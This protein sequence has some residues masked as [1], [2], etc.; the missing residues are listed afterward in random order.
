M[1]YGSYEFEDG[2]GM[3][4]YAIEGT[5]P[6][7]DCGKEID[8]GLAYLCYSCTKYFCGQHLTMASTPDGEK[9]IEFHCFAGLSSQCCK[10]CADEAEED[11][12]KE[13]VLNAKA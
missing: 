3:R 5:C 9:L 1:G 2:M 8:R 6:H 10:A 13:E 11:T 7:P 4:G 12:K